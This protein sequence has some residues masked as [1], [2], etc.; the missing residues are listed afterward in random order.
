MIYA[1][2]PGSFDPLHNGHAD[3]IQRA[4]RIYDRL[5]V[6]VLNNPLKNDYAFT[7][8]ERLEILAEVVAPLDNVGVDRFEGLLAEY[9]RTVQAQVIVKGLR[10]ISDFEYELQMA[11]LNRQ[12]N[13]DVETTFIMT[14]TRWSYVSSTR[15]K[16]LARYGAD[17]GKLV[18]AVTL[19][20]LEAKAAGDGV[21]RP[22]KRHR[23]RR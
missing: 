5:T 6:A 1:V 13:P 12:L 4:A 2:Y 17:V 23:S 20:R 9:M 11:H 22:S 7:T 19:R 16:E 18:P 10:A 21:A 8:E 14:A 15:V 3:L